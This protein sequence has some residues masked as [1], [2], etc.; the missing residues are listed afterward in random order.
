[1]TQRNIN[2]LSIL[3]LT[4]I[5]VL[6]TGITAAAQSGGGYDLT[7]STIDSGGHTYS[8]GG[9][10]ILGSTIGQ[11]DT[12]IMTGGIYTLFGGFW[13][14]TSFSQFLYLPFLIR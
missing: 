11:A 7:W 14:G 12:A 2:I 4:G 13:S 6:L 10:Y 3:L 5:L 1:M 8:T 9:E